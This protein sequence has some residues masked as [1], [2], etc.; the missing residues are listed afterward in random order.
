M[1]SN[2]KTVNTLLLTGC[3]LIGVLVVLLVIS[4]LGFFAGI[5][6]SK[7]HFPLSFIICGLI[8][9]F[10]CVNQFKSKQLFINSFLL[11]VVI[12]L[13]SIAIALLFY[14]VSYDGQSY[15]QEGIYQ[16]KNGWNPF[17]SDLP[18]NVNMSIYINHYSKGVEIPQSA[19][20]SFIGLI[21]VAKCTNFILL[22]AG[23]CLTLGLLMQLN[24]MSTLNC[25]LLSLIISLNPIVVNQLVSTYVDGQLAT[26]LLCFFVTFIWI[27]RNPNRL[28][29]ILLGS[30]IIITANIKF[31]GLVYVVVF[32]SAFLLWLLLIKNK[33]LFKKMLTLSV[34][35]GITAVVVVGFNPYIL[36]TVKHSH[37][38]YPLMGENKVDIMGYNTP[39]G[40]EG[41][42]GSG[43]FFMSL[44]SHTDNVM[45]DNN[46][47]V[48]L[49]I[50]F[51]VNKTDIINAS[52]IDSRIAGFGPLFS[53]IL[54]LS[55][56][57]LIILL[58]KRDFNWTLLRLPGYFI[59]VIVFSICIMPESW[60]ARYIPQ[61]WFVPITILLCIELYGNNKLKIFK[62]ILY[63]LFLINIGF[64]FITF[65]WNYMM[66][67]LVKFQL[68]RLKTS[69]Q[70]IIVQ[71][72]SASSNRIRFKEN[73]IDYI[74]KRL[75]NVV[76]TENII[77]SDSRFVTPKDVK[78]LKKSQFILWAEKFQQ[79]TGK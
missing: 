79:V 75:D 9:Y 45:P 10:P 62:S 70:P 4:S 65:G 56:F 51:T 42:T 40:F 78:N 43:K 41:R 72:G 32:V 46:R 23:C 52:K 13:M 3:L 11:S 1:Q 30:L 59:I 73:G 44:F 5:G 66:T 8:Y 68:E 26:L 53:G 61:F 20:Y 14:D 15:H 50:P 21:E 69:T 18:Q 58:I 25:I 31:T 17:K 49:K 12:V 71:W 39:N 57:L 34:L 60:W 37:P 77:R 55:L 54:I 64:S 36:N 28:N 16:L 47:K 27:I 35:S 24:R 67:T 29:F 74:E 63:A 19:I 6:I 22:F 7:L 33:L 76:N 48:Q 2:L 38:F